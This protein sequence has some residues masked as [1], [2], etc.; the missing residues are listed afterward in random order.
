MLHPF[1][2][3]LD[4]KRGRRDTP[5]HFYTSA[6]PSQNHFITRHARPPRARERLFY[7]HFIPAQ[8]SA[9]FLERLFTRHRVHTVARSGR[10]RDGAEGKL[11]T[12][13]G[14]KGPPSPPKILETD[15]G[16]RVSK[17]RLRR[18]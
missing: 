10:G 2:F 4:H 11:N 1:N 8:A 5:S 13:G 12:H 17:I 3:R 6:A 15:A 9:T 14:P 16:K 18:P 7:V